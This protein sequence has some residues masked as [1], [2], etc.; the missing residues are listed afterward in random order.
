MPVTDGRVLGAVPGWCG[1]ILDGVVLV[2]AAWTVAYHVCLLLDLGAGWALG[3]TLVTAG[4]W[5]AAMCMSPRALPAST[6]GAGG[7][8]PPLRD[9]LR[10]RPAL[11]TTA[12]ALV[13]G[14][15]M[16]LGA[17]WALVW[18]AWLL[19]ALGGIVCARRWLGQHIEPAGPADAESPGTA[20]VVLAWA[21]AMA[22]MAAWR[23]RT[24]PDDLFYVNLAQW[25]AGHGTFPLRDT[26]FSD[27]EFPIA[28]WPPM[29]SYDAGAGTLGWVFGVPAGTVVYAVV[30]PLASFLSVVAMWRLLR[31]WRVPHV[32][33]AM[34]A[35]V[36]FLLVDGTPSYGAPGTLF[37]TRLWQGKVILLCVLVPW[38]LARLVRYADRPDRRGALWLVTG[39]VA[40]VGSSTTAMF[41]VP[42]I[43]VAGAV[44]L[45]RTD[46]RHAAVAFAATAAYPLGAG[47]VTKAVGGYSADFFEG[48]RLYRFEPEWIGHAV[49]L[50]GL[51][52]FLGVSAVLLG[53]LLVPHRAARL[54]MG[55]SALALGL[56][57]VPG[58]TELAYD[59]TGLGPT[60][61]RVSWACPVALLVGVL[62][63]RLA[64]LLPSRPGSTVGV[65]VVAVALLAVLGEPIFT[66]GGWKAPLDWQ[67]DADE[68]ALTARLLAEL[69]AGSR[70]LAPD[71]LA[72]TIAVSSTQVKTV[73]PRDY[74][75]DYLMDDAAFHYRDRLTL[76]RFANAA[77]Q[78][79]RPTTVRALRS[80]MSAVPVDAACLRRRNPTRVGRLERLGMRPFLGG[81]DYVCLRWE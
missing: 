57:L 1:R 24:N 47:V 29:A 6:V 19:A 49:F 64:G 67:R 34:S 5:V 9:V 60:L 14:L 46:R 75:M 48:R 43:A 45:V 23:Y 22:V 21:V 30:P 79:R 56:V 13:A 61:W 26:I 77:E 66:Y 37:V 11:A 39:S 42:V 71:S 59:L 80:A 32:A 28:N 73:A 36:V 62:V 40:S 58:A 74:Y 51:L 38:L 2:L 44:P 68:R 10:S 63:V 69:P 53:A 18:V 33:V 50:D 41:L 70:I 78:D 31:A 27:L 17:P 65:G 35:S 52:A 7:V 81:R 15:A 76:V 12:A 4:A 54:S 20:A 72:I 25:V 16:A 8:G 3:I 55:V